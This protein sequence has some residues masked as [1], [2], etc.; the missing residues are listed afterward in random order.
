MCVCLNMKGVSA[1]LVYVLFLASW[2]GHWSGAA[3]ASNNTERFSLVYL[4]I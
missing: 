1:V 2:P 3:E 4:H